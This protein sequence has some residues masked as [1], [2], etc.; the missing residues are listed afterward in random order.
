LTPNGDARK[1]GVAIA[2]APNTPSSVKV[3]QAT[4]ADHSF[5]EEFA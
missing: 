5:A 4:A 2:T 3:P 1:N